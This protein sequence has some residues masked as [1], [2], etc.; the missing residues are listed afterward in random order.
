MAALFTNL[1]LWIGAFVLMVILKLEV[2]GEG[3]PGL[4]VR[5][6]YLGRWLFLAV[7]SALQGLLVTAGNL[8]IGVQT[9]NAVAF[10]F[11]GMLIALAYL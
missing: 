7:I 10:M 9:V 5:Q 4:T 1:S 8:I 3:V 6:G 11:T 2:D